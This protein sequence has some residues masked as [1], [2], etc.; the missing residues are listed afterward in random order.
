MSP[1]EV[2][3]LPWWLADIYDEGIA[4]ELGGS[5]AVEDG[6]PVIEAD[7]EPE[8]RRIERFG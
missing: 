4:A 2:T 8:P 5:S 7:R 3:A 1:D 6:V